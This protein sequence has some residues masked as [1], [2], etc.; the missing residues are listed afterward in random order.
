MVALAGAEA[1]PSSHRFKSIFFSGSGQLYWENGARA[2]SCSLT[3]EFFNN[4]IGYW[5]CNQ[6]SFNI[7]RI[8]PTNLNAHNS[9]FKK[10]KSKQ[11]KKKTGGSGTAFFITSRGHLITNHHVV[12]VLQQQF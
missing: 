5:E 11:A 1:L 3:I 4:D 2:N 9:K 7:Q 10:K 12:E 6:Y 8:W